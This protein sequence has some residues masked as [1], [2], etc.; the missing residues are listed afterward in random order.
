M[1]TVAVCSGKGG[2]GKSALA[3]SLAAILA[4]DEKKVLLFDANLALPNCDMYYGLELGCTIGHVV[5]DNRDLRDAVM[6]TSSGVDLISGGSGWK[7]LAM[8]TEQEIESLILQV[9]EFGRSYDYVIFDCASGLGSRVYPFL[10]QSDSCMLVTTGDAT[11]L[12]DTYALLKSAWELKPT[13]Q[14]GLVVN[15]VASAAQGRQLAK[16]VQT[17][18]GQFLS[19]ELDFWGSVRHD[20]T[21]AKCCAE[22]K[23][24][25]ESNPLCNASQDLVDTANAVMGEAV[26]EVIELSM[27]DRLKSKFSKD[28][29]PQAETTAA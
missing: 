25:A 8:M 28:S 17:I 1:K 2:V 12:M 3:C 22:R 5:R 10:Q 24:F 15:H 14:A 6:T 20:V 27:L 18:V 23:A 9:V 16:E 26:S 21:V 7:E 29:E 11:S 13:I 19:R 4:K